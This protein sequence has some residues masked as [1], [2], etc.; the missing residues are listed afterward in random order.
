MEDSLAYDSNR[1]QALQT[2]VDSEVAEILS[3]VTD[4]QQDGIC[5][6]LT[7]Q[8]CTSSTESDRN[9]VLLCDWQ[10]ALHLFLAMNF[11]DKLRVEAIEACIRTIRKCA[12]RIC[13]LTGFGDEICSARK[14]T[15]L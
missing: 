12:N 11:E 14:R 1:Y 5:E 13:V 10:D 7:R 4:L 6:S 8:R 9:F 15:Q 3:S 2:Y